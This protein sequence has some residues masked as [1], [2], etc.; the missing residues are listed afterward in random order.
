LV[1]TA[2]GALKEVTSNLQRIR[3]LAVQSANATNSSSDR[4]AL[5]AEVSQLVEEI[6]RVATNTKFNGIALLD[7]TFSSQAF[8]VGADAGE[9]ISISSISSSL[10]EDIGGSFSASL[11]GT[12]T[13]AVSTGVVGA[14]DFYVNGIAIGAASADGVST[15]GDTYSAL[16]K[17]NGLNAI[18]PQTG[19]I[20]TATTTVTGSAAA[21]AGQT[22]ASMLINNVEV[23][24]GLTGTAS[25]AEM[26]NDAVD[27]INLLTSQTGVTATQ[28]AGIIT[29][30]AADGRNIDLADGSGGDTDVSGF[31][32]ATNLG[33]IAL[34]SGSQYG[35]QF[36]STA[37]VATSA[38]GALDADAAKIGVLENVVAT[39][40]GTALS[41]LSV[42]SVA[43]ASAAITSID[44]ALATIND[45]RATLGAFQNRFQS[46]VANLQTTSENLSASRSRIVDADFAAETA[47]LTKAQILQ[48]SGI[49][50]LAQANAIPQNVLALLQ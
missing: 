4:L 24:Y 20:A 50:M 48:Q 7:G 33:E 12:S 45:T 41:S 5:Q 17:A 39:G 46:V 14:A 40:S 47:Q 37:S 18:S 38:A 25:S 28:S 36:T 22:A 19:V 3:E 10:K 27:A 44:N 9:T 29:L 21:T 49:A 2:E 15:V 26:A 1:Q 8:Q 23:S 30:T 34:S 42:T 32:A 35:I 31:G 16:S 13:S 6:D 43:N 11:T